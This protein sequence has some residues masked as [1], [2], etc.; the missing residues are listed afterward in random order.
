M[1]WQPLFGYLDH[2][3][4]AIYIFPYPLPLL[5]GH[6]NKVAMV[7]VTEFM[8]RLNNMYFNSPRL[9]W[10][11]LGLQLG[12][13]C[14]EWWWK[15]CFFSCPRVFWFRSFIL[16]DVLFWVTKDKTFFK[17][18]C[19][20]LFLN[21]CMCTTCVMPLEARKDIQA[22]GSGVTSGRRCYVGDGNRTW[23]LCKSSSMTL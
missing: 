20:V 4:L 14:L 22:P 12:F 18:L 6:M 13:Q 5:N 9:I 17:K 7:V 15:E 21:L 23:V 11:Q 8:H 1:G 3:L 16:M 19:R 2:C 10:L